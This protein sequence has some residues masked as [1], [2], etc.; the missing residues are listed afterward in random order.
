V[1]AAPAEPRTAREACGKRV[2]VALWQC[3]ERECEKPRYR[4][5]AQ[6]VEALNMKR[7]REPG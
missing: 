6:C 2:L 4:E 1:A 7:A 3:M 5:H